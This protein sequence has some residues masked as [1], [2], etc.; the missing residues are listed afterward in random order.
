MLKSVAV[1]I[2]VAAAGGP[3]RADEYPSRP[4]RFIVTTAPGGLMDI[5]A[6]LFADSFDKQFHQRLVVENRGGAG[7]NVGVEVMAKAAP[8]G[9]TL[10]QIQIGNVAVNPFVYKDL[11]FDVFKDIVPVAPLTSSPVIVT[12]STKLPVTNLRD[13]IALAKK[14]PGKLNDG[15]AG[16]GTAPHLAGELF[17]QAAGIKVTHIHYRGAGPAI[18]DVAAGQVD[19]TFLGLGAVRGQVDAGL[20]KALAVSQPKRLAAA[21]NIPT[22]AEAGL[23][24]FEFVTWFGVG[25]PRGTPPEVI[26]TLVRA[27]HAMQDDP[28]IQKRLSESGLEP[29]E[30]SQAEFAKRIRRDYDQLGPVVEALGIKPQ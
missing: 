17:A 21:P 10:A 14:E 1:L 20:V 27:I 9:Y 23:P 30:E 4:V 3:V 16:A 28:E 12:V 18:A 2:F 22:A 5:A 26:A 15:T 29:L 11:P 13:L 8:D 19:M 24:N 7:G 25:A 6:R